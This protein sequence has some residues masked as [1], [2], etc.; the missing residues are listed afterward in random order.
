[1]RFF[2]EVETRMDDKSR[3]AIPARFRAQL[4]SDAAYFTASADPC[5]AVFARETFEEKAGR[6]N[7]FGDESEQGREALRTFFGRTRDAVPDAQGRVTIQAI[8]SEHAG[9][10]PGGDVVVVGA[11]EYFEIWDAGRY[12][13]RRAS[14]A[15]GA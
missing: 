11:G 6:V 14:G 10:T 7:Q 2:G 1:M 13:S 8:H 3:I 9:L 12:R 5:I 4:G 15:A